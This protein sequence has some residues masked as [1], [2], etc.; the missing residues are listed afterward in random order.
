LLL[1]VQAMHCSVKGSK[2]VESLRFMKRVAGVGET[3]DGSFCFIEYIEME[4]LINLLFQNCA[5]G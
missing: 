1:T 5:H 3:G 4:K 2:P